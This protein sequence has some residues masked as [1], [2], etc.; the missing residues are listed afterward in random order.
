MA[1]LPWNN[2]MAAAFIKH[3]HMMMAGLKF[4]FGQRHC[5]AMAKVAGLALSGIHCV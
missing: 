4:R 5:W 2:T 1:W 3:H